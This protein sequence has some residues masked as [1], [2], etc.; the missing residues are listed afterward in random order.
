[1]RWVDRGGHDWVRSKRIRRSRRVRW[2]RGNM[3]HCQGDRSIGVVVI[4]GGERQEESKDGGE[5][6]KSGG[7]MRLI[8]HGGGESPDLGR[9]EGGEAMWRAAVAVGEKPTDRLSKTIQKKVRSGAGSQSE[10]EKSRS[11]R[12]K[13]RSIKDLGD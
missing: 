7:Q 11:E 4:H 1:M 3:L 5:K 9:K 10:I 13:A 6:G 2:I 12:M 8:K